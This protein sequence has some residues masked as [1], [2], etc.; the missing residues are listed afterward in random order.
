MEL[1]TTSGGGGSNG[2]P[3]DRQTPA[4]LATPRVSQGPRERLK[5]VIPSSL[6]VRDLGWT[7]EPSL[8][9]TFDDGPDRQITPEV[10]ARL[11]AYAIPAVFFVIGKHVDAAPELLRETQRLGHIIGNHTYSH[12]DHDPWFGKYFI[13]VKRCQSAVQRH[14][15]VT[16]RLFRPPKGH[17]SATSLTVPKLL[18][19]R[20]M[21]WSLNVRDW[22]CE[23]QAEARRAAE[24]LV[25]EARPGNIVLL[26]DDRPLVLS[27]LDFALPRLVDAGFDLS[28]AAVL[29]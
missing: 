15:G 13:D 25:R 9:F 6:L 12:S 22:A 10:L 28:K 7:V 5:S 23:S 14:A 4:G 11:Q 20:T 8:L 27:L 26:H 29:P 16:P 19:L 24:R 18:G 17:L 1:G 21:N 3:A 2:S